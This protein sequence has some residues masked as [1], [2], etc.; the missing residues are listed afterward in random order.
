[1]LV[2]ELGAP[3]GRGGGEVERCEVAALHPGGGGEV[4]TAVFEWLS[5]N[6]EIV[7]GVLKV[8][9]IGITVLA[10]VV[11]GSRVIEDGAQAKL[12]ATEAQEEKYGAF[13]SFRDYIIDVEKR[14][15]GCDASLEMYGRDR[16][17]RSKEDWADVMKHCHSLKGVN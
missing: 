1:M 12:K 16:A 7:L 2:E 9:G 10:T 8:A 5:E 3:R 17:H 11:G 4:K 15:S 14:K 13:D 6:K